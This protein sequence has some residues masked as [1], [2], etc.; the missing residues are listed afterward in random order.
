MSV[1]LVVED[2]RLA[3]KEIIY[4]LEEIAAFK[5]IVEAENA[6]QAKKILETHDPE[7]VFLDIHLPKMSGIDFLRSVPNHP[8]VILTTAFSDYALESYQYNVVDYLLKPI[9]FDRFLQAVEKVTKIN[10]ENL[11]EVTLKKDSLIKNETIFVK[12]GYDHIQLFISDIIAI[13]SDSDYTEII[14]KEKNYL[15]K[16]WNVL[17]KRN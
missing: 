7:V 13:K 8:K 10:Y 3:R 2:S 4:L 5:E 14:T 12:S 17:N 11:D 15:N 9:A 6:E 16:Y 1:C